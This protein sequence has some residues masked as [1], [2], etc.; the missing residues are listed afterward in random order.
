MGELHV[1][2]RSGPQI[3]SKKQ[4][5]AIL[6]RSPRWV[7]YRVREGMPVLERTD[8]Y[9]GRRYDVAAVRAWLDAGRPQGAESREQ[10]EARVAT[11]ERQMAELLAER[12][13]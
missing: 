13:S 1:L 4:L 2:P 3:V 8:R 9:G 11:L 5:C 6:D 12:Q 10:L 7:D